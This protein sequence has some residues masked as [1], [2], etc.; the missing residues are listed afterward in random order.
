MA[1]PHVTGI[2]A[3]AKSAYGGGYTTSSWVS[4]FINNAM[5]NVI[6]GDYTGPQPA[7][8]EGHALIP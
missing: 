5:P 3:V 4:W 8:P 2:M 1:A 6:S 7:R